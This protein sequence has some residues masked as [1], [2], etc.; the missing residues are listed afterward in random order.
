MCDLFVFLF[1]VLVGMLLMFGVLCIGEIRIVVR[2]P[3]F[4]VVE[5]K[6]EHERKEK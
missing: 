5:Y 6:R 1:G 4:I 2:T 3:R